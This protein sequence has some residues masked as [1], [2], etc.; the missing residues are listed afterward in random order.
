MLIL[1]AVFLGKGL[2][3]P[4]LTDKSISH[5]WKLGFG[6]VS[7]ESLIKIISMPKGQGGIIASV[8]LAN[9]PQ[10][11]LSFLFLTYNGL[12]SSMLLMEEWTGFANERKALRVSWPTGMQR[13]SYWLQLPY[14]YGVP[15]LIV[16][17]V[18]H[19]LV[20]QSLFL[21]H[22]IRLDDFLPVDPF[23]D[24]ISTCGYSL[25]AMIFVIVLGSIILLL[26]I[27]AGSNK[28]KSGMP[29]V[30]SCSAAISAACHSPKK[31]PNASLLP[32]MWGAVKT[33]EG[34]AKHCC[35]SSLEVSPPVEGEVYAG[36]EEIMN[37]DPPQDNTTQL[38]Q[39]VPRSWE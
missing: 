26:G 18:L 2:K 13:S 24:V 19:W 8:L 32:L 15:L 4:N 3:N 14:K 10:A 22:L 9:T 39:R 38:I 34:S 20:S 17:G 21:A 36:V 6:A 30:G 1:T 33:E 31:D 27:S 37:S 28:Y 29:L 16:S 12:L 23:F 11:L 5:L 25:I 35:F 7:S